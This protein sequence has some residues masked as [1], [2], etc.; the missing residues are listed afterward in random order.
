MNVD[1]SPWED[2]LEASEELTLKLVVTV[3]RRSK[4][5]SRFLVLLGHSNIHHHLASVFS[6]NS[7]LCLLLVAV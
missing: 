6:K 3:L 2:E 1:L 4:L 5:I 7:S